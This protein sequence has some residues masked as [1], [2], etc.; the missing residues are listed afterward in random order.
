MKKQFK[1]DVVILSR[2]WHDYRQQEDS[3]SDKAVAAYGRFWD[4]LEATATRYG[5][6]LHALAGCIRIY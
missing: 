5:I 6:D 1:R 2:A 3:L 4:L